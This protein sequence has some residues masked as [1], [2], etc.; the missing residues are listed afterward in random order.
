[1]KKQKDSAREKKLAAILDAYDYRLP[2]RAIA[3]KPAVPRDS[4]RLL[5]YCK[6]TRRTRHG[7]FRAIGAYLPR[8]SLLILNDTKVIPARLMLKKQTGG[9]VEILYLNHTSDFV[10][11][12]VS[13]GLKPGTRLFL[14]G[15]HTF[16]VKSARGKIFTLAPAFPAAQTI[17]FFERHGSMPIPPYIKQALLDRR[18]LRGAYQTVFARQTGSV[19]APTASLHF[20]KR[21]LAKL[22]Q[23]GHMVVFITHHVNLGTFAPL[24]AENLQ[25][26]T[27]HE[28]RFFISAHAARAVTK[29]LTEKTPVIA[30]GTTVVRALESAA[31]RANKRTSIKPGWHTTH[32]FIKP[33]YTFRAINGMITNFHLPRS[34]L[35][36]LVAAFA[37]RATILSIYRAAIKN[38]YRFYSFGDA[39]ALLP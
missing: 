30:C 29:A 35:L 18:Q 2:E 1:M 25:T 34:S 37:G 7:I 20:T 32:L 8:R 14:A 26:Q 15:H 12:L 4:A 27:L 6:K 10:R 39:M 11:A 5:V 22:K 28:E 31:T 9:S 33:G 16:T 38:K 24:T 36:M 21:L 3:Q 19:A 23:Q 13:P 17:A